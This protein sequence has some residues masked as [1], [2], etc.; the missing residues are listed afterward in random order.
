MST[1]TED[2][3]FE[4]L[5]KPEFDVLNELFRSKFPHASADLF[6]VEEIEFIRSYYWDH[7]VFGQARSQAVYKSIVDMARTI[8][9]N[10][11][12]TWSLT[13]QKT[14]HFGD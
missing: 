9:K 11:K 7:I 8:A 1:Y 12:I 2:Q 10:M 4:A 13:T 14:I 5:S 6:S 3:T